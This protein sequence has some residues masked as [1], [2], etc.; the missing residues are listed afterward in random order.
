MM[1]RESAAALAVVILLVGFAAYATFMATGRTP[2]PGPTHTGSNIS[3][4]VCSITGAPVGGELRVLSDSGAPIAGARVEGSS[5]A[6]CDG[7]TQVITLPTT[8]TNST[9]WADLEPV[10]AA[11]N[12]TVTY[13]GRAYGV[14]LPNQP[15]YATYA[16]LSLPSER[17]TTSFCFGGHRCGTSTQAARSY[18]VNATLVSRFCSNSSAIPRNGAQAE[19][20][21]ASG[22][23][24]PIGV[25]IAG[26]GW[27]NSGASPISVV[28]ICVDA[29]GL[30]PGNVTTTGP[31]AP[32]LELSVTPSGPIQPGALANISAIFTGGSGIY[33]MPQGGLRISIIASDGSSASVGGPEGGG[34]LTT[35]SSPVPIV[36]ILG[37][38]IRGGSQPELS[39][40]LAFNSSSPISEVDIYVNGTYVGTVGV[41]HD[42]AAHGA[43]AQYEVSY[44]LRIIEPGRVS[45]E[46]GARYSVTFVAATTAYVESSASVVLAA[47]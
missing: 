44:S 13:S 27:E 22:F 28:A 9:G 24:G 34:F 20:L 46:T 26:S 37:A 41:G 12:L 42:T 2:N 14:T 3:G 16:T 35:A 40:R 45:I 47:G 6:Y 30:V 23:F 7:Q 29:V 15:M 25:S 11:Y 32:T 4:T 1:K 18:S 10:Y 5:S 36:S 8:T 43:P 31:T 17:L 38:S 21:R 19:G 33:Y 39:A